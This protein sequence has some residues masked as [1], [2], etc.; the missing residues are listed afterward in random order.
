MALKVTLETLDDV[1]AEYQA[2]YTERDGVFVL[3]VE[4]VDNHPEVKNLK[5]AYTAEKAKRAETSDKLRDA[6]AGMIG[7]STKEELDAMERGVRSLPGCEEDRAV[8][9]NAIHA[10][11]ACAV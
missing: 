11:R 9:L 6:L 4:G 2:L 10:L 5:T 1:Q 7:A 8:A 3:D